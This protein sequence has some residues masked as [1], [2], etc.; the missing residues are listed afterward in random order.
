ME[1]HEKTLRDTG[2][3]S[4]EC[5]KNMKTQNIFKEIYYSCSLS[6]TTIEYSC[7]SVCV[8]VRACMCVCVYTVTQK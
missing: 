4:M 1:K 2:L 8:C 6:V 5:P 7:P 3:R